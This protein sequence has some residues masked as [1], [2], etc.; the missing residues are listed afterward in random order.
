METEQ[1]NLNKKPSSRKYK[2]AACFIFLLI[3]SSLIFIG[4]NQEPKPDPESERIIREA[5]AKL[6]DKDPNEL[7]DDDFANILEFSFFREA[8][9]D[10][11]EF[12]YVPP[13]AIT[14]LSDIR[15]LKKFTNLEVLD[16]FSIK[17]PETRIPKWMKYLSKY[18]IISLNKKFAIDLSPIQNLHTLK[19]LRLTHAQIYDIKPLKTI[20]NLEILYIQNCQNITDKQVEELQKALPNC[21]IYK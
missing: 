21:K 16:L 10:Q 15:F 12:M 19:M 9:N 3:V 18:G 17:Y 6:L 20:T 2:I 14:E 7:T 1:N 4:I 11:S 13:W 8:I 5:A